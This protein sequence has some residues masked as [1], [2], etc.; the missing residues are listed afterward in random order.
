MGQPLPF[1][2]IILAAQRHGIIDPLAA[3]AGISH[4]CRVPIAGK[5]LI[6]HVL[7]ALQAT[8]GLVHLRIVIEDEATPLPDDCLPPGPV[9]VTYVIAAD[10]LAD[11]V[12]AATQDLDMATIVTTADNVLLTPAAVTQMLATIAGGT[13]VTLAMATKQAVLTAH[14]DGQRRFYRF[15]DDEY[16]NCNLYGFSG[17]KAFRAAESFRGGGQ[18]AKKPKRLLAAFGLLNVILFKLGVL[19]LSDV[20]RR[21][22]ARLHLRIAAVVLADGSHAIDVDNDRTYKVAAELLAARSTA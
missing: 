5:P 17:A 6:A 11:S 19:S 9:A 4:K 21:L 15:K 13:D 1:A 14:P 7:A 2:A 18:F 8:P 22:S 20:M 10:N 3:Q 12:Y 16:S